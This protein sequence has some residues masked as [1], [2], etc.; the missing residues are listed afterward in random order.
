[1]KKKQL[2][3]HVSNQIKLVLNSPSPFLSVVLLRSGEG[4]YVALTTE[5][6]FS[7]P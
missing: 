7:K 6:V 3:F 2:L 1:M 5:L 4:N